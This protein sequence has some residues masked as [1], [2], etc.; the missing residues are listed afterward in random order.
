MEHFRAVIKV[1]FIGAGSIEFTRSVVTDLCGYP[2]LR[3]RLHLALHDIS[4]SRLA[5]AE[6]LVNRISAQTGAGAVVTASPDRRAALDGAQYVINE[7][8][9]GG[10][11]ATKQDFAIPAGYGVRQTIGDTL[12]IGG[13]F[14]GLRT[15][16]VTMALASDMLAVCPDA[17][18]LTYSN[19]MAMLP[20]ALVHAARRADRAVPHLR[21]GLP[22]QVRGEPAGAGGHAVRAALGRAAG[23]GAGGGAGVAVHQLAGDRARAGTREHPQRGPDH[24]PVRRLLRRGP[25]PGGRQ[26]PPRPSPSAR[27]RRSSPRS[28]GPSST[29]W[30]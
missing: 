15:I 29:W 23:P 16:P 30:S 1:T 3:G 20:W 17:Y 22:G 21:G 8:Q 19:P 27:C 6:M 12:G 9:V 14:R 5:F 25:L 11:E 7:V 28:T 13:I 24:Q 4:A 10:Y 18:L 26:R 2:E